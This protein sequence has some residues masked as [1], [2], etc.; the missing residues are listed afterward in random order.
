MHKLIALLL[1]STAQAEYRV[2]ELVIQNT[3]TNSERVI[4]HNLDPLQY[5]GYYDLGPNEVVLYRDTWMCWGDTS[6]NK[7]YCPKPTPKS[8]LSESPAQRDLA[9]Q[10]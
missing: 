3:E 2:F 6:Y 8:P 4:I 1:I 5:P 10:N 7:N 9:S